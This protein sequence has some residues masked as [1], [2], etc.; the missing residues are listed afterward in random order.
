MASLDKFLQDQG[1]TLR[2]TDK[3][4][5]LEKS[6]KISI[7]SFLVGIV[8]IS[9]FVFLGYTFKSA[10]VLFYIIAVI[11]FLLVWRFNFRGFRPIIIFDWTYKTMVRKSVYFFVNSKTIRIEGYQGIDVS[12][13]DLATKCLD[14]FA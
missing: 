2:H 5:V 14:H 10:G 6:K 11:I 1:Y 13:V 9:V 7:I 3:E 4:V 12:V 8:G